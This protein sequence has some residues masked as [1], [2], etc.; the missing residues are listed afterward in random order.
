MELRD[1][2]V[3]E[4][5][6]FG[7]RGRDRKMNL[8]HAGYEVRRMPRSVVERL[9]VHRMAGRRN[10]RVGFRC[11]SRRLDRLVSREPERK[12][13]QTPTAAMIAAQPLS[14][15]AHEEYLRSPARR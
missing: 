14:A 2:L 8:A 4:L 1:A 3:D 6:G 9:A 5:L 10:G 11:R 7:L 13:E 12:R 15:T